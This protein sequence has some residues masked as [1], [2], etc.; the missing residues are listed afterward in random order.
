MPC[1]TIKND[2]GKFTA[3]V[4]SRG[5]RR[6]KCQFCS[7]YSEKLCDYELRPG[8]TCDARICVRC[9]A[10]VPGKDID[11]CPMHKHGAPAHDVV[12]PAGDRV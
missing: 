11:F 7:N 2:E 12:S 1:K 5:Q 4:C 6:A 3:I 8:K 9:A 10:H